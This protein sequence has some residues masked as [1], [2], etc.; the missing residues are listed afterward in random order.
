GVPL[1]RSLVAVTRFCGLLLVVNIA[2]LP[3][4]LIPFAY[5]PAYYMVNGYLHGREYFEVV[6]LRYH[7]QKQA[8]QLR[9]TNRPLILYAGLVI[10]GLL[11]I[12]FVNLFAPVL[13][14]AFMAHLYYRVF[15]ADS[16]AEQPSSEKAYAP[17]FSAVELKKLFAARQTQPA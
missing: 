17:A 4:L 9:R 5:I 2:L 6:G 1:G 14:A 16:V 7:T 10:T 15:Y 8:R 12:P 3:L 13:S 11:T